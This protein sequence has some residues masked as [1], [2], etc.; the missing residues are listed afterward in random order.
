MNCAIV[1][2]C[3]AG[4]DAGSLARGAPPVS[5]AEAMM[6]RETRTQDCMCLFLD[7]EHADDRDRR[8]EIL[9]LHRLLLN[10]PDDVHSFQDVPERR[11]PLR[12]VETLAAEIERRLVVEADE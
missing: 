8:L 9:P 1:G 3:A 10:T 2:V 11:R 12:I 4:G 7:P 6:M 5:H